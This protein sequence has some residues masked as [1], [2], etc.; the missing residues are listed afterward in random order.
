MWRCSK[1]HVVYYLYLS[2]WQKSKLYLQIKKY[3]L[4]NK[5][6][7]FEGIV[8]KKGYFILYQDCS[9][10]GLVVEDYGMVS[11]DSG[12]PREVP[13]HLFPLLEGTTQLRGNMKL[14]LKYTKYESNKNT[15]QNPPYKN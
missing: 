1:H 8:V 15:K 2:K 6:F 11:Q 14:Q 4:S 13:L 5:I 12:S 3:F 10:Q 7:G 9:G